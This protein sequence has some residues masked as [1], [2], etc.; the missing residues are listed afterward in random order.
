[1]PQT[2]DEQISVPPFLADLFAAI[3]RMDAAGYAAFFT[4]DAQWKFG[5]ADPA[6]G[7]AAVQ[8]TAQSVFDVLKSIKH[9]LVAIYQ[10]PTGF[11]VQGNVTYHR[12]DDAL[13]QLPFGSFYTIE[14]NK[15]TYYQTYMDGAPLFDGLG[16]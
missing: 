8:A 14:N 10:T 9:D 15:I 4:P 3:D 12:K 1:M 2:A 7:Q 6:T 5:N 11:I 16:A 13:I